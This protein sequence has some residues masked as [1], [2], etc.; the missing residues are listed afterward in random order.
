MK[1]V[2]KSVMN[3]VPRRMELSS[4]EVGKAVGG[5]D[6]GEGLEKIRSSVVDMFCMRC[7]SHIQVEMTSRRLD[8]CN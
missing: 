3:Q 2:R 7:L 1:N 8:L 5:A 6:C 4:A